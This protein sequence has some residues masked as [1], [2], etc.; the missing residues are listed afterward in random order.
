MHLRDV[1][2]EHL[3]DKSEE[4]AQWAFGK[5]YKD[6]GHPLNFMDSWNDL[7]GDKMT[8]ELNGFMEIDIPKMIEIW[9]VRDV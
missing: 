9:K 4:F 2:E 7:H 8:L 1:V 6:F 5:F 3:G